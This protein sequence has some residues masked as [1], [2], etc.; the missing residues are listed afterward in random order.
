MNNTPHSEETKR[1]MREAWKHRIMPEGYGKKISIALKGKPKSTQH[2]INMA[3]AHTGLKRTIEQRQLMS[4]VH[5]GQRKGELNNK[6]KGGI[7]SI[8]TKIRK[9]NNYQ[10]WKELVY[11]R[12]GY[13]CRLCLN[14][15]KINA[16][17]NR[18]FSEFPELRFNIDNGIT[19]CKECHSLLH[20]ILNYASKNNIE[21]EIQ[22]N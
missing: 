14:N 18:T 4:K 21:G 22:W 11:Q 13:K 15:K 1:K 9:S 16:H 10:I 2:I 20:K 3:K 12:D 7:T 17:H 6:W 19:L 8:M 5:L